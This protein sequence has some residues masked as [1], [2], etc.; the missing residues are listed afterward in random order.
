[1]AEAF[2]EDVDVILECQL[3]TLVKSNILTERKVV[4]DV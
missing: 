1:M 2:S 3:T 4:L